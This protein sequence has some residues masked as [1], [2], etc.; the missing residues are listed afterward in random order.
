MVE[1]EH[2]WSLASALIERWRP[3]SYTFHLP[4]GEM[5]ITLQD[6]AYQLGLRIDGD[7]VSG[8]IGGWEQHHQV[9]TI[10]ELCEQIL[11]VISG[12]EDRQSQTKWTVKLTWFHNTVCRELEQDAIEERLMRWLPLLEDLDACG[13]LSWDSAVLAWL[14]RQMC[15]ATE[16]GQRN[17]GGCV[18]LMLSWAYHRIPLVRPD[19]FD[20]C[21]FSLVERWVQYRPDNATGE[22]RLRQY[23]R[24]LNGIEMLNLVG[25]VPP[26]IA[27]AD[28]S[29]AVVCPLLCF[30]IV[31]WH[32]VDRV[33]HQFN[34]LRHI[35][36]RPLNID[37][38]HRLDGRF[39]LD[40]RLSLPYMTW[41]LQWA[42]TK[43]FGLGDQHLVPAGVVPEDLPIHHPLALDLH[44]PVDGH[45]PELRPTAEGGRG[46]G[47]R[48]GK[49][50][51]RHDGGRG[52]QDPDEVPRQRD[53]VSTPAHRADDAGQTVGSLSG[54]VPGDYF[55]LR[56]PGSHHLEVGTSHQ[57]SRPDASIHF[58]IGTQFQIPFSALELET[59]PDY[60]PIL[61]IQDIIDVTLMVP[62]WMTGALHGGEG[63]F[64]DM[65]TMPR[66][67]QPF[68]QM[69]TT[70]PQSTYLPRHIDTDLSS[71]SSSTTNY[72]MM[73]DQM[74]TPAPGPIPPLGMV[75][76]MS[77]HHPV[78]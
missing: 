73:M 22:S 25:L 36:T 52:R 53:P 16:H 48:R 63:G 35:P 29:A 60:Q 33:V 9:W 8:C 2:D 23:R 26:A 5:T 50:R 24:T 75:S 19:G 6:V 74:S 64:R 66:D 77:E 37:D 67:T 68:S 72:A 12:P 40:L 11:G 31:E 13:R 30:A 17:L 41:Y 27:E 18:S 44:Q 56:P 49:G 59:Q 32:Q 70:P 55:S 42:H 15:R 46:R 43:L 14:Y 20:A 58:D 38:M 61:D 39:G 78:A 45:L 71:G 10:E 3:E 4:C 47:R 21:R 69:Y 62:D 57:G 28:A 54:P 65:L 34:G 7:P 76:E 51:G 1:F